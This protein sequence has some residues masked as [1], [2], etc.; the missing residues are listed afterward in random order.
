VKNN[1]VDK[2]RVGDFCVLNDW[3]NES[4]AVYAI[5]VLEPMF[6]WGV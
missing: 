2:L 1:L 4:E 5:D 6:R 3:D